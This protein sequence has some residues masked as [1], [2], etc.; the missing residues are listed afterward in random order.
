[1][2]R[3]CKG[4]KI[5][6]AKTYVSGG[7]KYEYLITIV[8]DKCVDGEQDLLFFIYHYWYYCLIIST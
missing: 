5:M 6:D 4:H 2:V 7:Q 3:D 8:S 1:M